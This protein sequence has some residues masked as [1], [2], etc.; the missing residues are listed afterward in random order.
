MKAIGKLIRG[1]FKAVF[2]PI[3]L[4]VRSGLVFGKVVMK[5]ALIP[6]RVS[7]AMTRVLGFRAVLLGFVGLVIG[8]L[9]APVPGRQL[10]EKLLALMAGGGAIP[11]DELADKVTFELSHAPRTWHL[12]PQPDVSVLGGRVVLTGEVRG[13]DA[14]DEFAR[15]AAAIPGVVAVDNQLEV[16]AVG[17][18]DSTPEPAVAE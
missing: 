2:L 16:A 18:G 15:V 14:R 12:E 3:R 6:L 1:L 4:L 10:R 5:V 11:D 13:E 8:L 7:R 17:A 9:I